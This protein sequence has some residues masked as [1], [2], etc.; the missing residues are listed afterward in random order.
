MKIVRVRRRSFGLIVERDAT[1]TVRAPKN[2]S[3]AEI[4]RVVRAKGDW[5]RKKQEYA[6]KTYKPFKQNQFISGENFYYLGEQYP[7]FLVE[8]L[9]AHLAFDGG[10]FLLSR[11]H[12]EKART[13]FAGWYRKQAKTMIEESVIHYAEQT[14]LKHGK[15][16]LNSAM[17]R[18][19]SCS[20]NGNLNFSWRLAM[21][22]LASLDYVVVHELAH[23]VHKN[24]SKSFWEKVRQIMPD[25]KPH[26][27]WLK[28]NGHLLNI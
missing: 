12:E 24:H 1:L 18:W 16:K 13:V 28:D 5:I 9:D 14:G 26:E 7:L 25:Y 20:Y 27:K 3:M 21:A 4:E 8:N 23:L 6:K 11:R 15:I 22:P 17:K 10:K 19:G 2:A